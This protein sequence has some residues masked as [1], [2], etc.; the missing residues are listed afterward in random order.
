MEEGFSDIPLLEKT[1]EEQERQPDLGPDGNEVTYLRPAARAAYS[2]VI[3]ETNETCKEILSLSSQWKIAS[4]TDQSVL[5]ECQT[6]RKL[7]TFILKGHVKIT[8]VEK[9]LQI[10]YKMPFKND[11][12]VRPIKDLET[13]E[14]EEEEKLRVVQWRTAP[15]GVIPYLMSF[16]FQHYAG[17]SVASR[18]ESWVTHRIIPSHRHQEN[19]QEISR[20]MDGFFHMT[21]KDHSGI[22][23]VTCV[24]ACPLEP[25]QEVF[26]LEKFQA[27][28]PYFESV[29]KNWTHYI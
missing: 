15:D 7:R 9:L 2:T 21:A 22:T 19:V 28:L 1:P 14:E 27:Y 24:F 13:F 23:T 25:S 16:W 26:F 5:Y 17:I 3:Q 11:P 6:G 4:C 12:I 8:S 20:I 10:V 29:E 18:G